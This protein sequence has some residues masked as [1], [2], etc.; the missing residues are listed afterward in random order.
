M[1]PVRTRAADVATFQTSIPRGR[2]ISSRPLCISEPL[3]ELP[4]TGCQLV[5]RH[6][7]Q[8]P[9]PELRCDHWQRFKARPP[10]PRLAECVVVVQQHDATWAQVAGDPRGDDLGIVLAPLA[11][12]C[13][14]Q[15]NPEVVPPSGEKRCTRELAVAR[16]EPVRC[17]P[18]LIHRAKSGCEI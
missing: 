5:E 16:P 2:P 15:D 14:P 18:D 11:T 13:R 6:R 12:P 4:L 8:G 17:Q 1:D 7:L 3:N 9:T 10:H